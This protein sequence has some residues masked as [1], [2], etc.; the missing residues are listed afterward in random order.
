M[1]IIFHFVGIRG[2]SF[3]F[4]IINEQTKFSSIFIIDPSLINY[5]RCQTLRS[6]LGQRKWSQA[7]FLKKIH[8]HLQPPIHLFN[9]KI[10]LMCPYD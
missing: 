5:Q 3:G 8:T 1:K 6:S 9:Y 2:L 10:Y 7:V 4:N